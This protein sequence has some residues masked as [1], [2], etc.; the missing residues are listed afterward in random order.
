MTAPWKRSVRGRLSALMMVASSVTIFLAA[1]GFITSDLIQKDS[2]LRDD[3]NVRR[4]SFSPGGS[5]CP[6]NDAVRDG[7]LYLQQKW[8]FLCHV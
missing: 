5:Q 7:R 6:S 3:L 2:H 8:L 4:R 1:V